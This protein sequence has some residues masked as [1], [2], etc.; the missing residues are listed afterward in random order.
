MLLRLTEITLT[1]DEDE[2]LL[3]QKAATRLGVT[4]QEIISLKILRKSLDAR[5]KS[6][7]QFVYTLNVEV[8]D[9]ATVAINA[10]SI[11]NAATHVKPIE[12]EPEKVFPRLQ[13]KL[14]P[15]IVGSGPAGL[16]A[17]LR[18]TEYGLSPIILE[19]GRV[20]A[21]RVRDVEDFWKER[22]LDPESN[23]QFGEGGAGTFSDGKLTTRV[24]DPRIAYILQ[25]FVDAGADPQIKYLAKPHIGTDSLRTV[26]VNLRK[27]LIERGCEVRFGAKLSGVDI[28]GDKVRSISIN[29]DEE[30]DTDR[31]ILAIGH[32]ARDT[33]KML[34]S[35]GVEMQAK[36]FA[37]GLRVEHPQPLVDRIQYGP[38]FGNDSLPPS[39]YVRDGCKRLVGAGKTRCKR[40]EPFKERF[41]ICKQR[42]RCKCK[43]RGFRRRPAWRR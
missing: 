15:V 21:E 29:E 30:L 17:A 40:H 9:D 20:V 10:R 16:F 5:K 41:S 22:R 35:A 3:S 7:I 6:R 1:L 31:L 26:V 24:D 12:K 18:L 13:S 11:D 39:E 36:P 25:S 19:R 27:L 42:P 23:V 14:R 32:S 2:S 33:Y 28:A 8:D 43:T 4:H 37:I 34:E 38:G